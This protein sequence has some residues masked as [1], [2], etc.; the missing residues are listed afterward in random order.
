MIAPATC[1]AAD[2]A[3]LHRAAGVFTPGSFVEVAAEMTE[4]DPLLVVHLS[5]KQ[6]GRQAQRL[7]GSDATSGYDP[8]PLAL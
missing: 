3:P 1:A 8:V 5:G 6:R 7:P 2:R 4:K